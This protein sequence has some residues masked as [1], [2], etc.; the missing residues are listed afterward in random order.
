ML[1]RFLTCAAAAICL[2]AMAGGA[3]AATVVDFENVDLS[4]PSSPSCA[5]NTVHNKT[6]SIGVAYGCFYG[7]TDPADFPSAL[8]SNVMAASVWDGETIDIT[9]TG[10]AYDLLSF[11]LALGPYPAD[12]LTDSTT[13]TGYHTD[14][15]TSV[16]SFLLTPNFAH[17]ELGWEDLKKV[18]FSQPAGGSVYIGFDN[19]TYSSAV[20][21]TATW[22][23]LLAGFAGMGAMIRRARR[24]PARATA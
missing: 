20:P 5:T 18:S 14:G 6:L 19:I 2:T 3:H 11:D 15:T 4:G 23:M 24:L 1:K 12:S 9:H 7:P 8:T 22:V 10:G 21:E 16:A 13:V 17:F